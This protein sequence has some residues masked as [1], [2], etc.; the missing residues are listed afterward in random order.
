MNGRANKRLSATVS[1]F[2]PARRRDLVLRVALAMAKRPVGL[3]DASHLLCELA[4]DSKLGAIPKLKLTDK[5]AALSKLMELH[6]FV[7]PKKVVPTGDDGGPVKL[8]VTWGTPEPTPAVVDITPENALPCSQ[9]T[10]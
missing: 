2:P 3:A 5:L 7:A 10:W 9:A 8:V 1:A 4:P 6:G